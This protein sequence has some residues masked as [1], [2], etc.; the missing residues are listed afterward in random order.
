[1]KILI[2]FI[3]CFLFFCTDAEAIGRRHRYAGAPRSEAELMDRVLQ[4]LRAKDTMSYYTLFP[5]LDTLWR[6]VT[7]NS[8][9]SPEAQKELAEL[10]DHPTVLI[11]LDPFYNHAI[12]GRFAEALRKGE[13]SGINWKGIVMQRYELQKQGVTPGLEG[14]RRIA[15]DRF[16]GYMFVR[17]MLSSTT[18]CITIMEIQK[19][20][21]F[22]CG[23]QVLNVLEASN[24]DQF[25]DREKAERKHLHK[26]QQIDLQRKEDSAKADTGVVS[27]AYKDSVRKDSI[28]LADAKQ[29]ASGPQLP[30]D[31]AR[32]RRDLLLSSA[33]AIEEDANKMRK[34]VVDRKLYKGKFDDEIPVELYVRYMK[35]AQGKVTNWDG[36]YKFGDMQDYV[37][38]EIS[39]SDDGKW[40][41]EEPVGVMDLELSSKVYTGSWTNGENQTGYDVELAQKDL[42]QAK[43]EK[44]DRILDN[45]AGGSTKD[46]VITEKKDQPEV[47]EGNKK[48]ED[49]NKDTK[50][51][52]PLHNPGGK[53][54]EPTDREKRKKDR[55]DK[56]EN[57]K[58]EEGTKKEEPKKEEV[59]KEEVKKE[60]PK[61]EE[62]KKEEVKKE[63]PKKNDDEDEPKKDDVKKDSSKKD[64]EPAKDDED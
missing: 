48:K 47:P 28:N 46:Q 35:N 16:K 53:A 18:Y 2:V 30:V 59:K 51:N 44:L 17:D 7:H 62:V 21:G 9:Q 45:N 4:C 23:G 52:D 14:M 37:R 36:L 6:M 10:R 33:P 49:A 26:L 12:I 57:A 56:K 20:N 24:I 13:D 43:M 3:T 40:V 15:P 22:F 39:K 19:V 11:D 32:I 34:E 50:G 25:L 29:K 27:F 1:M 31:S 5:P 64:D 38:L 55:A 8:D 60:T 61:K 42:S 54:D 41:M 58:K 63:A